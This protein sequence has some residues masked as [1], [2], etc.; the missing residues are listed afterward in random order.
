MEQRKSYVLDLKWQTQVRR[1][2]FDGQ[3]S[4]KS[5]QAFEVATV[6]IGKFLPLAATAEDAFGATVSALRALGFSP[7]RA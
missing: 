5:Q 4:L 3:D 2:H 6:V 1:M 7:I